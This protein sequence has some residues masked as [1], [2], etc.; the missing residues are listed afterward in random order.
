M[1]L[2]KRPKPDWE[3]EYDTEKQAYKLLRP[4]QGTDIPY[5]Y[6]EAIYDKSPALIFSA[7]P[8]SNLFHLARNKFPQSKDAALQNSLEDAFRAL[9][10]YGVECQDEKLD[11]FLWWTRTSE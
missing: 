11:N 1:S 10:S 9:T 4:I 7:I 3:E 6:G 2:Q 5:F 8:G